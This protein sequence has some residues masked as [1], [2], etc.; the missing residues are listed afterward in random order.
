[1]KHVPP[2]PPSSLERISQTLGHTDNGLTGSE[3]GHMLAQCSIKDTDP[4]QTKWI[5][6]YNAFAHHQNQMGYSNHIIAFINKSIDPVLHTSNP[7]IFRWYRNELNPVLSF[8]SL[9]INESGKIATAKKAESLDEALARS[10]RIKLELERRKVH[11]QVLAY[12]NKELMEE[13]AFHAVFEAIKGVGERMRNISGLGSDGA[14]LA[15]AMF[16]IGKDANPMFS[17]NSLQND[18]H[19]SEQKGFMNLLIGMFGMFR[20]PVAHAPRTEWDMSDT[21][22]L[23]MLTTLSLVHRKLDVASEHTKRKAKED[24]I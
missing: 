11:S 23:D 1:M 2:F 12:C 7:D 19:K 5:R 16:S 6:I 9:C 21:D 20:N 10:N 13:N 24:G 22:A 14:D 18:S 3:I 15:Q 17:I 8:S 4:N